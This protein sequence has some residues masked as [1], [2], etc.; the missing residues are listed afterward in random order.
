MFGAVDGLVTNASL[1]AGLGGGASQHAVILTG[2]AAPAAPGQ[3]LRVAPGQL[4]RAAAGQA[5]PGRGGF[6]RAGV[7]G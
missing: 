5:G 2:A 7:S 4:L 1:I 6:P 3:L